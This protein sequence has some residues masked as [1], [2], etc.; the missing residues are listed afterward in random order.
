MN[1]LAI[2]TSSLRYGIALAFGGELLSSELAPANAGGGDDLLCA[3]GKL[4]RAAQVD[5]A[6]LDL[7]VV[8]VGP[9]MFTG[10]RLG[11]S[12]AK[13]IGL[14]A[15]CSVIG[16]SSLEAL[17]AAVP[18]F[19]P[20]L[21]MVDARMGEI[22]QCSWRRSDSGVEALTEFSCIRPE[23][24][25]LA[26][27]APDLQWVATGSGW[28]AYGADLQPSIKERIGSALDSAVPD[29]RVMLQLARER[30]QK[31]LYGDAVELAPIYVRNKVAL[32]TSER[33]RA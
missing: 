25:T 3:A 14:A 2:T 10:I 4:M 16:V 30:Y 6:A 21:T 13:G 26:D 12:V 28:D 32:K 29:P 19:E 27:C 9:G 22:Y 5:V 33:V 17:A 23:A 8:D 7:L 31:G 18:G 11:V 20:V 15:G 1:I 24:L